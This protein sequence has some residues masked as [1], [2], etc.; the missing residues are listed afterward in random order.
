MRT[1]SPSHQIPGV[2]LLFTNDHPEERGL[3]DAV[4]PDH[5][6]DP[7]ARQREAQA[8]EEQFVPETLDQHLCLEHIAAQPWAGR[9]VD[10]LE[11]ELAAAL[12]LGR[13]LLVASQPSPVLGL[14]RFRVGPCPLQFPLQDLCAL[15]IPATLD[16]ESSL[17]G[18]QVGGVVA[19]V[20]M[21]PAAIQLEDP[22]RDVVQEVPIVRHG[23]DRPRVRLQVS[24]QPLHRLCIQ[25][26]RRLIEQQQ[27]RLLQ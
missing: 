14:P 3:A 15:G 4:R 18:V 24:F 16:L 9:D 19:L 22:L 23:Q 17:L 7:G 26:V 25:M 2:W 8:V 12:G 11:V 27:V 10:L 6:D 21:G 20:R 5:T 13:Q 1:V